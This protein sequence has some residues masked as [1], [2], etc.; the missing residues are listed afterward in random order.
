MI[1]ASSIFVISGSRYD[2]IL[3]SILES[4]VMKLMSAFDFHIMKS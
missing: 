2:K 3:N 1:V 4:D